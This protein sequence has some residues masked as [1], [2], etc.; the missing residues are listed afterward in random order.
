M[1][2]FPWSE[3]A[4]RGSI[5][6]VQYRAAVQSDVVGLVALDLVLRIVRGAAMRVPLVVDIA[7]VDLHD[8]A[9]H[10]A[11]LGISLHMVAHL[12]LMAHEEAHATKRRRTSAAND[13]GERQAKHA[14]AKKTSEGREERQASAAQAGVNRINE[15][16]RAS[17]RGRRG[18]SEE[19]GP[20]AAAALTISAVMRI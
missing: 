20:G 6:L 13:A 11:R 3:P 15:S 18:A 19:Q 8:A 14:A 17:G 4:R 12:E 16:S 10:M 2:S 9:R 1:A 5:E 7:R